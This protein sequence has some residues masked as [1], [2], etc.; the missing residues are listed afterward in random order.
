MAEENREASI[1]NAKL[2]PTLHLALKST[3]FLWAY[4]YEFPMVAKTLF[5]RLPSKSL[6]FVTVPLVWRKYPTTLVTRRV[7]LFYQI[8]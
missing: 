7:L 3:A 5:E 2:S 1:S 6:L 4:A 8:S